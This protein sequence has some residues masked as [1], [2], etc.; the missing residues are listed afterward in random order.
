M[1]LMRA[2]AESGGRVQVEVRACDVSV[3][4]N[5]ERLLQSVVSDADENGQTVGGRCVG[6][7]GIVHSAGVL[8]DAQLKDQREESVRRVFASKV[9][10]GW[11]LHRALQREGAGLEERLETFVLFSSVASLF[12][13]FGQ[14]NYAA[15]NAALDS[16]ATFRQQ[17]GLRAV[18][19]QWGPW[20]EQGMAAGLRDKYRLAGFVGISND[21][22]LRVLGEAMRASLSSSSLPA[23]AP[24]VVGCQQVKWAAFLQ[25]Y[26]DVPP[27]FDAVPKS[28]KAKGGS[29]VSSELLS[30]SREE[31][32]A[33][34]SDVALK[35]AS[36]V[37]GS[38]ASELSSMDTP[39]QELGIDSLGAVELRNDLQTKLGVR[40]P[41]TVMFEHPTL[42]GLI[43]CICG[44]IGGGRSGEGGDK[45]D[46][47]DRERES[48]VSSLGLEEAR[49]RGRETGVLHPLDDIEA[50]CSQISF[51]S[52][53]LLPPTPVC[54][55]RNVLLTGVTGLVGRFQLKSLLELK[56]MPTLRVHCLVRAPD[57]ESALDRVKT[58]MREAG[59]WKP[60]YA[61]RIVPLPGDLSRENLG[62]SADR[63]RLLY[64]E[65]DIVYH[66]GADVSLIGDYAR[67][68]VPNL[69]PTQTVVGLCTTHRLKPLHFVSTL[70]LWP[71]FFAFFSKEFTG[72]VLPEDGSVP[73]PEEMQKHFP[74]QMVRYPWSKMGA[75]MIVK[76]AKTLGLPVAV[77]RLPSL[78]VAWETGYTNTSKGDYVSALTIATMQE[79]CFPKAVNT[80]PFTP[81][82]TIAQMIV[83]A[84]LLERR[85]HWFYHLMNTRTTT[86]D[87][88]ERWAASLGISFKGVSFEEFEKTIEARGGESPLLKFLPLM[89]H[90]RRYWYDVD[91][92]TEERRGPF[93]IRTEHIFEDL[94]HMSWPLG[95]DLLTRSFLFCCERGL[96]KPLSRSVQLDPQDI[97]QSATMCLE[98]RAVKNPSMPAWAIS[99]G[100]EASALETALASL[101]DSAS[102]LWRPTG[103]STAPQRGEASKAGSQA[104]NEASA[105][106]NSSSL[107]PAAQTKTPLPLLSLN[108]QGRFALL[109]RCRQMAVNLMWM[110]EAERRHPEMRNVKVAPPLV[111][112][113]CSRVA[114]QMLLRL[115]AE[116]P[117]NCA[118]AF[119]EMAA[120]YGHDGSFLQTLERVD[121]LRAVCSGVGGWSFGHREGETSRDPRVRFAREQLA[122][123]HGRS[124]S[125]DANP[126]EWQ[127]LGLF[128]ASLADEDSLILEHSLRS[129]SFAFGFSVPDYREWLSAEGYAEMREAYRVHRR[130]L[131]HLQWQRERRWRVTVG[132]KMGDRNLRHGQK[133]A[134]LSLFRRGP[135]AFSSPKGGRSSAQDASPRAWILH[136][137]LHAPALDSLLTEYPDAR[138]VCIHRE[139]EKEVGQWAEAAAGIRQRF[140]EGPGTDPSVVGP[141][142]LDNL[143]SMCESVQTFGRGCT[144]ERG[145]GEPQGRGRER[146]LF[147]VQFDD[148]T[149]N[150]VGVVERLY[151]Q[152]GFDLTREARRRMWD[153]VNDLKPVRNEIL[154][155][156][157]TGSNSSDLQE[158][159]GVSLPEASACSFDEEELS[160]VRVRCR[161]GR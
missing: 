104:Q 99:Q 95:E 83:E 14:A 154:N 34:V 120:P 147:H 130:F 46:G 55:V 105:P 48:L 32:R 71:A 140:F 128:G 40:L 148:L 77:Y 38:S 24:A 159:Y 45:R 2:S 62:L 86:Q 116:D 134:S 106:S 118:P 17:R 61:F 37:L 112:L 143:R 42:G 19:I 9:L 43:E 152:T 13:N 93:P 59:I 80:A 103:E 160:G 64:R 110:A 60:S 117:S 123:I 102:R 138:V 28:T 52:S 44:L 157:G 91:K 153:L 97:L 75:E 124:P 155:L 63:F 10:G 132:G 35:T 11:N 89:H 85:K 82:D 136:S 36:Q 144:V 98:E 47:V 100:H 141:E 121:D 5:C 151:R 142:M 54:R 57:G 87:E 29:A 88:Q 145:R 79:G 72:R 114:G 122:F 3:A 129:L 146:S 69:L 66:T 135:R 74:P 20:E 76:K 27:F 92:E 108:F 150:P 18:S 125:G 50:L 33:Y 158:R 68:R 1:R 25:R 96:Y 137:S 56:H 4:E 23:P 156:K 31:L 15:A 81:V 7:F 113:S 8:A 21:L 131:Q 90:W 101:C 107:V 126:A 73:D 78:Y 65:I 26:D 16:L 119:C 111:I 39:L 30:M 149:R 139:A 94:P 53:R 67:L 84:S 133:R 58:A 49:R 22:G 109:S 41:A 115:L 51:D 127:R 12:G 161:Q 70:A 6:R